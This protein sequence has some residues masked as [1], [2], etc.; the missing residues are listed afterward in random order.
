MAMLNNR[1]VQCFIG[2]PI[3]TLPGAGVRNHPQYVMGS[4]GGYNG[5]YYCNYIQATVRYLGNEWNISTNILTMYLGDIKPY[6]WGYDGDIMGY[7][8]DKT[9]FL[10]PEKCI[11]DQQINYCKSSVFV[12]I[13]IVGENISH[14]WMS[15]RDKHDDVRSWST[16]ECDLPQELQARH[17]RR[18]WSFE[19]VRFKHQRLTFY[20]HWTSL[21]PQKMG[22]R[23][24]AP[25]TSSIQHPA[26]TGR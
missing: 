26:V 6:V 5:I 1:R 16:K 12:Y 22:I 23:F 21:N 15:G 11:I 20:A 3:V 24:W 25:V 2:I 7:D 4:W 10:V 17:L 14:Q 13:V 8:Q 19:R 18:P 9:M